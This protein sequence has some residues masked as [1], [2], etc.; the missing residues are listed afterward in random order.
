MSHEVKTVLSNDLDLGGLTDDARERIIAIL[1]DPS[2]Y[3][4]TEPPQFPPANTSSHD[5]TTPSPQ[6]LERLAEATM[7]SHELLKQL[8]VGILLLGLMALDTADALVCVRAAAPMRDDPGIGLLMA[9]DAT[10]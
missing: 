6:T 9:V 10:L 3:R 8:P 7:L 4:D 2:S 5:Q 1:E